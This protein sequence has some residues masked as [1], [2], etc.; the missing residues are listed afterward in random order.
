MKFHID[1]GS[2]IST[3]CTDCGK[4]IKKN[5]Y[6]F[7]IMDEEIFHWWVFFHC[8][9]RHKK[10]IWKFKTFFKK[11]FALTILFVLTIIMAPIKLI[12]LPFWAIY[13]FL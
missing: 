4:H 13:E 6:S 3:T 12:C 8:L 2:N 9:A 1:T 5:I 10:V 11:L 7:S